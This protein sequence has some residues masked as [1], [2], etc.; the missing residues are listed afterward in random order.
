MASFVDAGE[1]EIS[2]LACLA[3][4][5]AVYDEWDVAG[6]RKFSLVGVG[7]LFGHSLT[8]EP[9]A[10]V[11]GVAVDERHAYAIV[12]DHLKVVEEDWVS[13]VAGLLERVVHVVVGLRIV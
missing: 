12:E 3:V 5:S 11:I 6:F 13:K 4:F 7:N 10:D 9:I 2:V 8:A 1:A